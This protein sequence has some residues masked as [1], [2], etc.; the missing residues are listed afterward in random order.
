MI[1]LCRILRNDPLLELGE[2]FGMTGYSPADS[3]VERV[4]K[5]ELSRDRQLQKRIEKI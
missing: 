5:E 3:T 1:Y 4:V 2:A